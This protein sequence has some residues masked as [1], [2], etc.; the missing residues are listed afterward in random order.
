MLL[1]LGSCSKNIP[2]VNQSS[3]AF[4]TIEEKKEFL[5]K[6][7]KIEDRAF[8]KLDFHVF[9]KDN[10]EGMVPGPSDMS[11]S[12]IA[13]VP[14]DE[15]NIWIKGLKVINK[16]QDLSCFSEVPTEID[17]SSISE[18]YELK[19]NSFIGVDRENAIIIYRFLTL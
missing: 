8:K 6:Y 10:S 7:L 18:W 4:S 16:K 14:Q 13:Q 17:Y 11:I 19:A 12:F 9:Y 3:K 1:L 5:A 15:I 2:A